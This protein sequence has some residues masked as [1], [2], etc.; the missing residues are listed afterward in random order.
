MKKNVQKEIAED[1]NDDLIDLND[2]NFKIS[3]EEQSFI[4][5]ENFKKDTS[6]IPTDSI[7]TFGKAVSWLFC[8]FSKMAKFTRYGSAIIGS[9]V[10]AVVSPIVMNY[11][12]NK[13]LDF[14]GKRLLYRYLVNLSFNKI[15]KYLKNKFEN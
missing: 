13:Y 1:L 11:D 5:I 12:I 3:D 10:G 4:D 14:Y 6:D 2:N 8:G 15:E 7:K 9:V